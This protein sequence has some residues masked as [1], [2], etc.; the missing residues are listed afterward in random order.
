MAPPPHNVQRWYLHSAGG[1]HHRPSDGSLSTVAPTMEP[2]DSFNCGA[3]IAET[4]RYSSPAF[5]VPLVIA[6]TVAV[7]LY[8][9]SSSTDIEFAATIVDI[10]LDL[11]GTVV[12][13]ATGTAIATDETHIVIELGDLDHTFSVGHRLRFDIGAANR[14]G[15]AAQQVFHDA[16]RPSCIVWSTD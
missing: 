16:V 15:L 10:G 12:A 3:P 9:A 7:E 4:L 13:S 14:S 11:N 2:V 1:A 8:A 5:M 6:G